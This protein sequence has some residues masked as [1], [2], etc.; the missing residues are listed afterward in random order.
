[1]VY[2]LTES[3]WIGNHFDRITAICTWTSPSCNEANREQI[4]MSQVCCNIS[5]AE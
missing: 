3:W 2:D 4:R 1:M 5:D